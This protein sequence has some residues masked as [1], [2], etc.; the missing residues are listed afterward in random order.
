MLKY[1]DVMVVFSE[2]PNEVTLAINISGCPC[3][4][5][6]CHSSYLANDIGTPL[7]TEKLEELLI[8]HEG[9]TAVCFMGGDA[10][11][12]YVEFLARHVLMQFPGLKIGWYSGREYTYDYMDYGVFDY[13]KVGPYIEKY[14]PLNA[15][16]TNQRLY[17]V[18]VK[19]G[20]TNFHDITSMMQNDKINTL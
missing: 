16:T 13:V 20:T 2:L 18:N 15:S 12:R 1:V 19:D 9:V 10:D 6:G 4:C 11:P 3:A 14:G 7:T 17:R 8:V 5:H